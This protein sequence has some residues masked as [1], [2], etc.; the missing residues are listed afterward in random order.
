MDYRCSTFGQCIERRPALCDPRCDHNFCCLHLLGH[1]RVCKARGNDQ[2]KSNALGAD[3]EKAALLVETAKASV[4]SEREL[5]EFKAHDVRNPLSALSALN[6]VSLK[7]P[8]RCI[9]SHRWRPRS[10]CSRSRR[11]SVSSRTVST[12]SMI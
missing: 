7:V 1:V 2:Q 9:G 3:S 5:N 4:R 6:S 11:I 10:H 12:L 8:W